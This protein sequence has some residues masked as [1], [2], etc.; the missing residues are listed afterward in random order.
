M[1]HQE[2]I[3][4][5]HVA[6]IVNST[7]IEGLSEACSFLM[8]EIMKIQRQNHLGVTPYERSPERTDYANGFKSKTI[9]T[10]IGELNLKVP[11]TRN[12]SFYPTALEQGVRADRALYIAVAEMYVNGVST[13]KV[14]KITEKLCGTE[15]SST[16]VSRIAARLDDELEMWR[17]RSIGE[18]S[19]LYLDA[20]YEKVRYNGS[21]QNLAILKAI[22]VTPEGH[23]SILG[24]SV[25]LSEAEVHWRKFLDSLVAR[26]LKGVRLIISDDHAG[27]KA[28]R[29]AALPAVNWQ[30]CIFHLMQNVN[31]HCPKVSMRTKVAA[32]LRKVYLADDKGLAL[33]LLRD[34]VKKYEE[35]APD[36]AAWLETDFI[37][38]LAFFDQPKDYWKK[39]RT[40]NVIENLHKQI[41]RR[42]KVCGL[43]PNDKSALRLISSICI[44]ISEDWETGRRY[45]KEENT[46][47]I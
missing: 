30:R 2:N 39:L 35:S 14:S 45:L 28:A 42:T 44:D 7:G 33:Q 26:G 24:V 5:E 29:A 6:E 46:E 15:I 8:N 43:F 12:S 38:G 31:H 10:G 4:M 41:R 3:V 23:K 47:I 25:S 16:Q 37:E 19:Y 17:N 40:S 20:H 13:R 9:K 11:Q 34:V 36:L 18:M 32:N 22:G 1:T 27:L 21:V